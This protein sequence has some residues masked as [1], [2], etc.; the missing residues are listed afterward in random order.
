MCSDPRPFEGIRGQGFVIRGFSSL[1]FFARGGSTGG[2]D[3]LEV[4]C[5]RL[6]TVVL[7]FAKNKRASFEYPENG[8]QLC[9]TY[10]SKFISPSQK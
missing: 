4:Q 5:S 6:W 3:R 2:L 7:P 1:S 10:L 9:A 8:R